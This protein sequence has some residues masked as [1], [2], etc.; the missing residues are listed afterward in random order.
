MLWNAKNGR[1][2]FDGASM[3]WV[4]FGW[5][6]KNFVILPGLSDGLATVRG[7]ALLL[8]PPYRKFFGN[9]T[10]W[11]FS[12]RDALLPGTSIGDMAEDQARVMR[13]LGIRK[14][15]VM[16]VSQGGMIAQ[17]LAARHPE[18][19]EKL[20]LAV[21]APRVNDL[22]RDCVGRWT[23][24]AKRGDH[25][26]LMTDTA[27]ASY[28]PEK[29]RRYRRL[30]PFLG[31]VGKPKSYDRF[32]ANAEAILGMDAA[33]ELGK[34]ACPTLIIGGGED[35]IVG[36]GAS[37]EMKEGIRDSA[38]YVYPALGHAAYEEAADFN[39]RVLRFLEERFPAEND[40]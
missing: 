26:G 22:I 23:E 18:T 15:A 33:D 3:S 39:D 4:S 13:I 21:S 12:R 24:Y 11:M 27:E 5:G 25:K 7:K 40:G 8:A 19:V 28:S 38:L 10:V 37:Y 9:Y 35:R 6:G 16:G 31:L 32:L 34:I 14:A 30:Y 2:S 1:T 20:V 17:F 36:I 29:L